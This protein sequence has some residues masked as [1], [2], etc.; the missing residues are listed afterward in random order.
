MLTFIRRQTQRVGILTW[1]II[2]R[3]MI[4]A[5]GLLIAYVIAWRVFPVF[6]QRLSLAFA[7][8]L[9]YAASAYI[10]IP[11]GIRLIRILYPSEQIP[12]NA[13]TPDGFACD[14][15]NIAFVG[16][17]HQITT[18]FKKAGWHE[19]DKK[20]LPNI[21]KVI[22]SVLMRS[23]Y[24][25]APFS[26][27]Y[28]FGRGQDLGF[29]KQVGDSYFHRHHVRLWACTETGKEDEH[30]HVTFWRKKI[31]LTKKQKQLWVGAAIKDTGLGIIRYHGQLTH[32]VDSNI[33]AERDFILSEM[34]KHQQLSDSYMVK[35]GQATVTSNRVIGNQ[36]ISSGEMIVCIL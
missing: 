1:R 28:L 17:K 18:A 12:H 9:T 24:P 11:A 29:Q 21:L 31:K 26:T 14:P 19:A 27:L 20:T 16:T 3:L 35:A 10:V 25:S 30:P 5:V 6:N 32:S 15:I 13:T 22:R 7:I 2:K 36:M 23:H 34:E 8:L 4:L 33:D